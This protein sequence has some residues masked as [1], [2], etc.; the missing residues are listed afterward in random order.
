MR[1][2]RVIIPGSLIKVECTRCGLV[3]D[4]SVTPS[5]S[6]Y[7]QDDYR[8]DTGDHIFHGPRGPIRRSDVFAD[9]IAQG[10][11][12]AGLIAPRRVLEIGSGRGYLLTELASRWPD[13]QCEGRELGVAAA[14]AAVNRGAAVV[15]GDTSSLPDASFDLVM[16]IA[17]VEHVPSPSAFIAEM[18]RLVKPGGGAVL[19]QPT[20]DVPSYDVFFVDHLHHFGTAHLDAYASKC[21]FEPRYRRVGFDFMP[22]FSAH[23]WIAGAAA[24]G[25]RWTGEP[26]LTRCKAALTTVVHDL[27]TVDASA[28]TLAATGRRFGVFGLHEVFA[29]VRAYSALERIGIAFGLDDAPDLPQHRDLPFPIMRPEDA[30]GRRDDVFLTMNRIYYQ[31]ATARLAALGFT[32]RPVLS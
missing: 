7:Y 22:N 10:L 28:S 14:T 6:T 17:V 24:T 13:A 5:S 25:W 9:W 21:G 29:L 18:R 12:A 26:S 3:R 11:A 23:V 16:A 15:Q 27:A 19:I 30:A 2:D 4:H 32:P 20:Q 1:S 8:I 31:Q